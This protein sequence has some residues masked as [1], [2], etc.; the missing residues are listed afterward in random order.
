VAMHL[1][2]L[3]DPAT[4]EVRRFAQRLLAEEA[5]MGGASDAKG[6][7]VLRV[8]EKLRRAVVT[9]AGSAGF[10]SLLFRALALAQKQAPILR[11]VQV[12]AEGLLKGL[13]DIDRGP[14]NQYAEAE[15]LLLAEEIG[16]LVIF[17]GQ[18]SILRLT[19]DVWPNA[20]FDIE[21]GR[22]KEA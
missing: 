9:L 8:F 10:N 19:N 20:F 18:A 21:D 7:T 1:I 13:D 14:Q 5:A 16:L 15:V 3:L 4:P 17:I 2:G 6:P 22:E 11:D 12:G